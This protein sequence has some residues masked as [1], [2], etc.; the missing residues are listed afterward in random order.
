MIWNVCS[1][2]NT[3]FKGICKLLIARIFR[4]ILD[5]MEEPRECIL[6]FI[7]LK[8]NGAAINCYEKM[9]FEQVTMPPTIASRYSSDE[10][11]YMEN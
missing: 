3:C 5:M 7:V 8:N 6:G 10:Y 2:V 11:N 9:G 4:K 1:F